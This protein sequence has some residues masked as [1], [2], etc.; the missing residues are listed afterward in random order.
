M[1]RLNCLI[2]SMAVCAAKQE[3]LEETSDDVTELTE[4]N[5]HKEI[6]E[7]QNTAALSDGVNV[8]TKQPKV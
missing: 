5:E 2:G 3:E 4:N 7:A 1:Y 8:P 6:S